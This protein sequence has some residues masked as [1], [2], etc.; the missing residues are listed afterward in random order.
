MCIHTLL[1]IVVVVVAAAAAAAAAFV[2]DGAAVRGRSHRYLQ[3][4]TLL[5]KRIASL[6][7]YVV[8]GLQR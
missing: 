7:C 1:V 4:H 2:G 6:A 8:A 5:F 3:T